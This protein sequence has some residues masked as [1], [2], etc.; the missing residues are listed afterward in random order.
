[1]A[2]PNPEATIQS[3]VMGIQVG[4]QGEMLAAGEYI[5]LRN[6]RSL[7]PT[8]IDCRPGVSVNNPIQF[9]LAD[10]NVHSI[11]RL[12]DYTIG[13]STNVVGAGAKIYSGTSAYTQRATGYSGDPVT[14]VTA[15]PDQSPAPFMYIGDSAKTSKLGF[16]S[17]TPTVFNHGI[18]PPTAAP[19][20][21]QTSADYLNVDDFNSTVGW[22]ASVGAL[23]ATARFSTTVA[24]Q[25][26]DSSL[27]CVTSIVPA[28]YSQ[29]MQVGALAT[30]TGETH[31]I[32]AVYPAISN[33]TI[34]GIMYD[35]GTTGACAIV[36]NDNSDMVQ[37]N[38]VVRLNSGGASD[39]YVRITSVHQGEGNL[40]SI[41]CSTV[42]THIAGE[43][44][45][46]TRSFRIFAG[47]A[48]PVGDAITGTYTEWTGVTAGTRTITKSSTLN[49]STNFGLPVTDDTYMH[50][51]LNV[52]DPTVITEIQVQLDVDASTNDFTRNYYYYAI[53]PNDLQANADQTLT[54]TSARQTV[55]QRNQIEYSFDFSSNGRA[56][57]V[58]RGNRPNDVAAYINLFLTGG[59]NNSNANRVVNDVARQRGIS[60]QQAAEAVLEA[61][62]V[63]RIARTVTTYDTQIGLGD[64]QW[65]EQLFRL[66][67][68][69]RVGTDLTRTWAD[70]KALRISVV[71]TGN[72]T[73]G[74]DDWW[75]GGLGGADWKEPGFG[76]IYSYVYR[77]RRTG[78]ALSNPSPPTRAVVWPV[79]DYI[80]VFGPTSS[81]PQVDTVEIYRQGGSLSTF[82]YVGSAP[83][84]GGAWFFVDKSSDSEIVGNILMEFDNF[85][86]WPTSDLPRTGTVNVVGTSVQWASGD[87][88]NTSWARGSLIWINGIAT[89]IYASPSS[90]TRLETINNLGVLSGVTY[91][92]RN[93]TLLGTPLP[94]LIGPYTESGSEYIFGLGDGSGDC[95]WTKGGQPDSAP[96][97][98]FITI[99]S[100]SE[101]LVGGCMY[102]GKVFVWSTERMFF[103]VP[104]SGGGFGAQ[105]VANGKGL[106]SRW[107]VCV[108]QLIYFM[109]KDGIYE[110]EGGQPRLISGPIHPL[111]AH[112]SPSSGYVFDALIPPL[113]YVDPSKYRL[114][115]YGNYMYF[116][117]QN[118][119]GEQRTL[120]WDIRRRIWVSDDVYS[121]F[122]PNCYYGLEGNADH[123]VLIG[124]TVGRIYQLGSNLSD[125]SLDIDAR[126]ST[127]PKHFEWWRQYRSLVV[128]ATLDNDALFLTTA[129]G[130][131]PAS[132]TIP[133]TLGFQRSKY[134]PLQAIQGKNWTFQLT[135][136]QGSRIFI[137]D[138]MM[139]TKVWPFSGNY[140]LYPLL[141]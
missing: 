129:D 96:D 16:I 62:G 25:L 111:F 123:A 125:N 119:N 133:N 121:D 64:S 110:S 67:S 51:S 38:M 82:T 104:L 50:I 85:Q 122:N 46:G 55:V 19:T 128:S 81:D 36:L 60:T 140:I 115:T 118:T 127:I 71:T 90:T 9:P 49:L 10:W 4:Q 22:S 29:A 31:K 66:G 114:F 72:V 7:T 84:S 73:I 99:T 126:I 89:P 6:T 87:T 92:M 79:R 77:S 11:R 28:A 21:L 57:A 30:I 26:L 135:F 13:A 113:S 54:V 40:F 45:T 58:A 2:I 42:N 52:S 97:T 1:M 37:P 70:V 18:A 116:C 117:Y 107:G 24:S 17:G 101:P 86:P 35:S 137:K 65:S 61:A 136:K 132:Y 106:Y 109:S 59:S 68:M 41:R 124:S 98:N 43:T 12:N 53:R 94:V 69:T 74:V 95:Y 88:F 75:V 91:E 93:A 141:G 105:E 138:C 100:S 39:E 108:N 78:G 27:P 120:V 34:Q 63:P 44:I 48:H 15:R 80:T 47:L 23:A 32:L 76:Y 8:T 5:Y 112:E 103:M 33:T 134:L 131:S 139:E 3:P 130:T 20:A 14:M 102:D 83:N 56:A